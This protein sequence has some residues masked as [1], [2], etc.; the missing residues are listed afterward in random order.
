M[1]ER[2]TWFPSSVRGHR[3]GGLVCD[4]ID[5]HNGV[6]SE[7]SKLM[8]GSPIEATS[9]G[10]AS[11][12]PVER[13][14]FSSDI[15]IG[16]SQYLVDVR[17]GTQRA[18]FKHDRKFT[19]DAIILT[20]AD[21]SSM[22]GLPGL[23][24]TLSF[25]VDRTHPI[26]IYTPSNAYFKVREMLAWFGGFSFPVNVK[27]VSEE[28]VFIQ[29]DD[30]EV[31]AVPN[32]GDKNSI[33]LA[34]V[35]SDV[36]G[37]FD[38]ETAIDLGVPPGPKFGQLCS[39]ESVELNDGTLVTPDD[40]LGDAPTKKKLVFSGKTPVCDTLIAEA[41]NA[42]ALIHD[43]GFGPYD[44]SVPN[45]PTSDDIGDLIHE[46][47]CESVHLTHLASQIQHLSDGDLLSSIDSQG[48]QISVFSEGTTLDI[49]RT[50]VDIIA[51]QTL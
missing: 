22:L 51:P 20:S 34:F 38:R 1:T 19:I 37:E 44:T 23:L 18:L 25:H 33:G 43:L 9:L 8:L 39:G 45:R 49:D 47:G 35:E 5:I 12:V 36:R 24:S 31:K 30:H 11:A 3:I 50:T 14:V 26:T 16:G 46:T 41:R 13:N 21:R 2:Q 27:E 29:E 17:E 48:I 10:C 15:R 6:E 40:V 28:E 4:R 7:R 32:D 42:T